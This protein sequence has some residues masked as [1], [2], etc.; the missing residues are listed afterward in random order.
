MRMV[1]GGFALPSVLIASLVMMMVLMAA[2]AASSGVRAELDTQFYTQL[3]SNAA[4]SGIAYAESCMAAGSLPAEPVQLRP[5]TD[6]AGEPISGK[7]QYITEDSKQRSSYW[8]TISST[9][10]G[11]SQAI[12]QGRLELL[13]ASTG[14]QWRSYGSSLKFDFDLSGGPVSMASMTIENSGT[15]QVCFVA[16][17]GDVYCNGRPSNSSI[18]KISLPAKA[19][20]VEVSSN[21]LLARGHVSAGSMGQI[22]PNYIEN[23]GHYACAILVDGDVYCWGNGMATRTQD[24]MPFSSGGTKVNLPSDVE[25]RDMVLGAAK[26]C[27][28]T[29]TD[30]LYCL[31]SETTPTP[32]LVSLPGDVNTVVVSP[33]SLSVYGGMPSPYETIRV[34]S[35]DLWHMCALLTDGRVFCNQRNGMP[36]TSSTTPAQLSIPSGEA[37]KSMSSGS[38]IVCFLTESGKIYCIRNAGSRTLYRVYT[39]GDVPAEALEVSPVGMAARA[40]GTST[41][42]IEQTSHYACAVLTNAELYCWGS[43]TQ[44]F[45]PGANDRMPFANYSSPGDSLTKVNLPAGVAVDDMILGASLACYLSSV[46]DLYCLGT[47]SS[48]TPSKIDLPAKVDAALVS[49]GSL[50]QTATSGYFRGKTWHVCARLETGQVY[51]WRGGPTPPDYPMPFS[52]TPTALSFPGGATIQDWMAEE[53]AEASGSGVI[54]Y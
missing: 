53:E 36:F 37:V 14:E 50:Y 47:G 4:K 25:V 38:D 3:A 46:G 17:G 32:S 29:T 9:S 43:G 6:C 12:S 52:T 22:L 10:S 48:L 26:A 20:S 7:S 16:D 21:G 42:T 31:E 41:P 49:P 33:T 24:Q 1:R 54:V 35:D 51:C 34:L 28:L 39:P 2:L 45:S 11:G 23:I 5:D 27:F 40:Y 19:V 30:K 18:T 8:V 13:R 44:N 15:S